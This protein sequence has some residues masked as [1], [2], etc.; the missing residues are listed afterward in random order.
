[1]TDVS[2]KKRT[3]SG[4]MYEIADITGFS[5][6][7]VARALRGKGY[8]K[9]ETRDAVLRVAAEL[10]YAPNLAAKTLKNNI[11]QKIMFCIPDILN[12]FYFQMIQGVTDVLEKNNYYTILAYSQHDTNREVKIIEALGTRFADGLIL[13]S[14][15]FNS[16]LMNEI[17]KCR[18]P[19]VLTNLVESQT[20][21]CNY[22]CVYV[23]HIR[24][25]YLAT[26][27]VIKRGH[28]NI[29]LLG[30]SFKEQTGAER[31]S[32]YRQ[33][34]AD[35]GIEYRE[36]LV[37]QSDF[38]RE[39]SYRDFSGFM[40]TGK[41]ITAV[42]ACSDLMGVSVINYCRDNGLNTPD[43]MA[44]VTLDDT[45]YSQCMYPRLTSVRMMQYKI[46]ENSAKLL[47]N[48]I[49]GERKEKQIIRLEPELIVREST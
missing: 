25:V 44:V 43:D 42:V 28:R 40:K 16:R 13:G 1:M 12:P 22:D 19:M 29:C 4:G 14:F 47:I 32:G 45:E 30:G 20:R 46:G 24:A 10:D 5:P 48:H 6:S 3:G 35:S 38:S 49:R 33:A 39:G 8:V 27:H 21:D 31:A 15:D 18:F 37:I 11:T 7:T 2:K 17:E 9:K 26:E 36:E 41:G 34:L 23:D